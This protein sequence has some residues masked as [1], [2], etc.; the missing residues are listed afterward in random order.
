MTL[1]HLL[2]LVVIGAMAVPATGMAKEQT[3]C[4]LLSAEDA[5]SLTGAPLPQPF[6]SEEKAAMHNGHDHK[7]ACGWFPKGFDLA[8]T[9]VP[10]D[11]GVLLT[12]HRLRTSEEARTFHAMS[13]EMIQDGAKTNPALGTF[14]DV[15]GV[16]EKALLGQ[17]QLDGVKMATVRFL[18]GTVAGQVQVWRKDGPAGDT[19]TAAAKRVAA[20][21]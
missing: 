2:K 11:R 8:T 21:L 9:Q 20:R 16:G 10:P 7:T 1:H 13:T 15:A 17:K 3:A 12:V 5:A 19:A 14:A 6:K 4:Q 18:K